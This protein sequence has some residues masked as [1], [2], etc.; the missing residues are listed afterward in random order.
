MS[1][2]QTARD[3]A[4]KTYKMLR[5]SHSME[6]SLNGA[7]DVYAR[8]K[9]RTARPDVSRDEVAESLATTSPPHK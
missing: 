3:E 1:D 6:V 8:S 9:R 5:I 7:I 2:E 4:L